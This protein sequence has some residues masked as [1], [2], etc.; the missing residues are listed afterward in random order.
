MSPR[1]VRRRWPRP[2]RRAAGAFA[3]TALAAAGFVLVYALGGQ[4]QAEG[5]LLALAFGALSYGLAVWAAELLP[6]RTVVEERE[7]D[8]PQPE[9]QAELAR[10]LDAGPGTFPAVM[11]RTLGLAVGA[12][13]L[14]AVVP[15]RSLLNRGGRPEEAMATTAW[16][17]G[18]PL[19]ERRGRRVRP[20]DLTIGTVL[21]VYP[22]GAEDDSNAVTV[23]VR[24]DPAELR[25]PADRED[26]TVDGIVAYSRVCTHVGCPVGLYET[27]TRHLLCPCHQSAFDVLRGAVPVQGPAARPLPQLPLVLDADGFLRAAGDFPVPIGPATW[28]RT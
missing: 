19:V 18:T 3:V 1:P 22:E 26:W 5:A 27:T 12:L 10:A 15:L 25:L 24:V 8:E 11:R 20:G 7:P 2:E 9:E 16:R 6:A 13:G 4:T 14:A 23:L 21:T 17:A 28:R